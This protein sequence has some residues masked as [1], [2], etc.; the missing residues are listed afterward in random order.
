MGSCSKTKNTHRRERRIQGVCQ[1]RR[2]MLENVPSWQCRERCECS[3]L[4]TLQAPTFRDRHTS[5][6]RASFGMYVEAKKHLDLGQ[7]VDAHKAVAL[8][9]LNQGAVI[10]VLCEPHLQASSRLVRKESALTRQDPRRTLTSNSSPSHITFSNP[11]RLN[12]AVPFSPEP[13][14][15]RANP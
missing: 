14:G 12:V 7:A 4:R 11:Q 10:V 13:R 5:G 15:V 3:K 2:C 1:M 6:K 9:G 8:G